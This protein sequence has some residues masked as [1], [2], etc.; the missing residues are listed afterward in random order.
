MC[1]RRKEEAAELGLKAAV[2]GEAAEDGLA[3][4]APLAVAC[5][6][7][8]RRAHLP[9]TVERLHGGL[10]SALSTCHSIDLHAALHHS[11]SSSGGG[12]AHCG[13]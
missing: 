13:G 2:P 11:L 10:E 6:C 9:T 7:G 3:V 4:T 5:W 12:P 8:P 1:M